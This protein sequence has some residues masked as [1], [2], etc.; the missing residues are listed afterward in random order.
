MSLLIPVRV[1]PNIN[2]VFAHRDSTTWGLSSTPK[3]ALGDFYLQAS[4]HIS[5]CILVGFTLQG[6]EKYEGA[7]KTQF[8]LRM[9]NKEK[10][11]LIYLFNCDELCYLRQVLLYQLLV[12]EHYLG[13]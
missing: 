11:Q 4:H 10:V 3:D 2:V 6:S 7:G 13:G 9:S 5:F 8:A 1:S 12:L